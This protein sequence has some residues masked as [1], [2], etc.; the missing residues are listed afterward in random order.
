MRKRAFATALAAA[1]LLPLAV[2]AQEPVQNNSIFPPWQ[3]GENND[4]QRGLPFT[5]PQ[6]DDLADFHGDVSDPKLVLYV[7]GNYFFAMAPLIAAFE[8]QHAEF[9]GRIYWAYP[10]T[11]TPMS[12]LRKSPP[13][14][15]RGRISGSCEARLHTMGYDRDDRRARRLRR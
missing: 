10:R 3:H 1:L 4:A 9:K 5:I 12:S 2:H 7:G 6:V 8:Q 11:A 15:S 14:L 13:G